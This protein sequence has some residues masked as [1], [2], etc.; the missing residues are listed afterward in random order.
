MHMDRPQAERAMICGKLLLRPNAAQAYWN[1][2]DVNLTVGE[3]EAIMLLA[4]NVTECV[5]YD[6]ICDC[7]RFGRLAAAARGQNGRRNV[8]AA[9]T[10]IRR[11]FRKIDAT[12][13]RIG[14]YS[15]IGYYW[16]AAA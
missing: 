10:R 5:S 8:R 1:A 4:S 16:K 6:A 11:K 14:N 9:I 13:D 2:E 15:G 12:F 3:Y 7:F